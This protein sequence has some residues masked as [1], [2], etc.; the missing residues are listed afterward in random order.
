MCAV[1]VSLVFGGCSGDNDTDG[2]STTTPTA[3]PS[4][5]AGARTTT[6]SAAR[7]TS[8][9]VP[10]GDPA[11]ANV[12]LATLTDAL[13]SPVAF[14]AHPRTGNFYVAEQYD[15]VRLVSPD[16]RVG[17]RVLELDVAGGNEQGVLGLAFSNDGTRLYVDYTDPDGHTNVAEFAMQGDDVDDASERTVLYQEQPYSNHNGGDV[18]IGPDGLLYIAFGDG[19]AGG[20]PHGYGQSTATKL[21]KILRIDPDPDGD[22]AYTVPPDNPYATTPGAAPEIWMLGLRN[23]WRFSFDRATGDL[24]IGDVGQ[25]AYE[26][27]DH[28]PAGAADLNFGWNV[29]EGLHEFG[30]DATAAFTDP[31]YE[32]SHDDGN[33]SVTGGFVYR[34][35]AI[36]ELVGSYVFAD[37]CLGEVLALETAGGA[38][39]AHDLG[40]HL[41]EVTSFGEDGSG[42]L[43]VLGRD[44]TLARLVNAQP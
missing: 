11:D 39:T 1:V 22:A 5:T 18:Q 17:D 25:G 34:G 16:G 28:A 10:T 27:V 36:P 44:G 21:G 30:G 9:T 14:A 35:A 42:E 4:T 7:T 43:Y 41:D 40:V 6:T 8:T 32:L 3:A 24:W 37:Y 26:E 38:V 33:C 12:E 29:R 19:G 23:P 13:D 31:V 2:A 15:G 20:D